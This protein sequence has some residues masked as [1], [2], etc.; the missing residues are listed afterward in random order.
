MQ[1]VIKLSTRR[2]RRQESDIIAELQCIHRSLPTC[3][4]V[5]SVV[6]KSA[7]SF[8]LREES[9]QI[10][11]NFFWLITFCLLWNISILMAVVSS[12]MTPRYLN[13]I[14]NMLWPSQLPNF[15][16]IEKV[17]EILEQCVIDSNFYHHHL[18]S[19]W[20]NIH[21]KNGVRPVQSSLV[22][23]TYRSDAKAHWSCSGSSW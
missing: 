10:N 13:Y 16:P 23:E 5:Q 21:G 22:P 17:W 6:Q 14:N 9:M 18:N 11:T 20:G 3:L 8:P 1:D 19:N 7:D 4:R 15:N 12:K 2:V